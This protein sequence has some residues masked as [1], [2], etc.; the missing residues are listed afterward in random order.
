MDLY[1]NW[2]LRFIKRKYYSETTVTPLIKIP[3]KILTIHNID[4]IGQR[5]KRNQNQHLRKKNGKYQ[6]L[7]Y[8]LS[9]FVIHTTFFYYKNMKIVL[10]FS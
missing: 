9:D 5:Q 4:I 8:I 1:C 7:F 3:K 6:V 10:H 2:I